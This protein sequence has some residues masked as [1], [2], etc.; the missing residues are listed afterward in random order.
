MNKSE[1]G[2][3]HYMENDNEQRWQPVGVELTYACAYV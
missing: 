2:W 1:D 3:R